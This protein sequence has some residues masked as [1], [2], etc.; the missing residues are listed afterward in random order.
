MASRFLFLAGVGLGAGVALNTLTVS[1]VIHE[2]HTLKSR[3]TYP[4][5]SWQRD[6]ELHAVSSLLKAQHQSTTLYTSGRLLWGAQCVDVY[7]PLIRYRTHY[8]GDEGLCV[9]AY[10]TPLGRVFGVKAPKM[11]FTK[12]DVTEVLVDMGKLERNPE[13]HAVSEHMQSILNGLSHN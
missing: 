9:D 10:L 6:E 8:S 7:T 5:Y 12:E 1:T 13:D 4:S 2:H 11:T 3:L